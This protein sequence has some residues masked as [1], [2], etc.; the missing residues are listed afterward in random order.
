MKPIMKCPSHRVTIALLSK[1]FKNLSDR[2]KDGCG[3]TTLSVSDIRPSF[4]AKKAPLLLQYQITIKNN[5][6]EK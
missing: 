6:N 1:V 2:L 4:E 3:N 5:K